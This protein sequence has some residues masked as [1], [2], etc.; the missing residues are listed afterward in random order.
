MIHILKSDREKY[1]D[2]TLVV[3]K[4]PSR[5]CSASQPVRHPGTV[6]PLEMDPRVTTGTIDENFAM[7]TKGLLPNTVHRNTSSETT[8]IFS[9]RANSAIYGSLIY[10]HAVTRLEQKVM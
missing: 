4:T 5:S 2:R 1:I 6:H 3:L 7:G 10:I 8:I 9:S